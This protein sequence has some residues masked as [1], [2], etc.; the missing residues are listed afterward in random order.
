MT[1]GALIHRDDAVRSLR[2]CGALLFL[3]GGRL[4]AGYTRWIIGV[5]AGIVDYVGHLAG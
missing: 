3:R 2:V 4:G 1:V 5:A